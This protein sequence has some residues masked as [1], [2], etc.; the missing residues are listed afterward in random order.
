MYLRR[1]QY[2]WHFQSTW[3]WWRDVTNTSSRILSFVSFSS[4][5]I[6]FQSCHSIFFIFYVTMPRRCVY[7]WIYCVPFKNAHWKA[8]VFF[9]FFSYR[10]YIPSFH[11]TLL[12]YWIRRKR[13]GREL[14]QLMCDVGYISLLW[15]LYYRYFVYRYYT[16]SELFI[17]ILSWVSVHFEM[18]LRTS[19]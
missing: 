13:K 19:L 9:F 11:A 7:N 6:E 3:E 2:P 16:K 1:V 15:V 18:M 4:S 12:Y 17:Y 5:S 8:R 14:E 10:I